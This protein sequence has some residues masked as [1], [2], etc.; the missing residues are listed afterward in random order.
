MNLYISIG[1]NIKELR[2]RRSL[3]QEVLAEK[4]GVSVQ[5]ISNIENGRTKMSFSTFV[6]VLRALEGSADA[7][8]RDYIVTKEYGANIRQQEIIDITLDC[9]ERE[10]RTMMK[11]L[12][13]TK[14]ILREEDHT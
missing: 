1:K 3:T 5:H 14:K 10:M 4:V 12:E 8:L 6:N 7:I 9:S 2:K 11:Y 13:A